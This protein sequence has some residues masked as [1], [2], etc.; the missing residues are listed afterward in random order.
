MSYYYCFKFRIVDKQG[1]MN[2]GIQ[3][4]K[5]WESIVV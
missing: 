1:Y 2:F 4:F 5:R 3:V